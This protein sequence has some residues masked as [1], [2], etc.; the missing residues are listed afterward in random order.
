MM[1]TGASFFTPPCS[2][3]G[4]AFAPPPT[5]W[6][7][8]WEPALLNT[9]RDMNWRTGMSKWVT[10][11]LK[12]MKW[13]NRISWF[14]R[15]AKLKNPWTVRPR[16]RLTQ[17]NASLSTRCLK[18]IIQCLHLITTHSRQKPLTSLLPALTGLGSIHPKSRED[19]A[20]AK[21]YSF[22]PS[23][24]IFKSSRVSLI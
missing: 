13:R 1:F 16:C 7:T 3:P 10:Q 9:C 23:L 4:T 20:V 5:C 24:E 12:R 17:R 18:T 14:P 11:W 22:H 8:P 15:K 2:S 19:F 21:M 6:E